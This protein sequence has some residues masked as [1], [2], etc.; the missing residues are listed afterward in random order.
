MVILNGRVA[1]PNIPFQIRVDIYIYIYIYIIIVPL[2]G[3]DVH[4]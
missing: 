3:D 1:D 2:I 4:L